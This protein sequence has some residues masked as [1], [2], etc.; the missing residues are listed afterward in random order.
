VAG[1]FRHSSDHPIDVAFQSSAK[2][3]VTGAQSRE[4]AAACRVGQA[5]TVAEARGSGSRCRYVGG[6]GGQ[7]REVDGGRVLCRVAWRRSMVAHGEVGAFFKNMG[8]L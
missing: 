5:A 7:C 1:Q 8:N 6:G 2:S 4:A 3:S